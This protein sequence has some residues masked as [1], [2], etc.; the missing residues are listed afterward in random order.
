V[1]SSG[2]FKVGKTEIAGKTG[3]LNRNGRKTGKISKYETQEERE[4]IK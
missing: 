2:S 1:W 3:L 4:T